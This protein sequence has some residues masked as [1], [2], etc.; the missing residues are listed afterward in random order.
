MNSTGKY[1][2]WLPSRKGEKMKEIKLTQYLRPNGRPIPTTTEVPDEIGILMEGMILSCEV[3]MTGQVAF[4]AKYPE[5]KDEEEFLEISNNGPEVQEVLCKL[6]LR[7]KEM[8]G[9]ERTRQL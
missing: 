9:A 8:R 1:L 3:L 4:Y 6:I 2:V 7:K 5:D